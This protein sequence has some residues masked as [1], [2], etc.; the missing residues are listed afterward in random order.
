MKAL[1]M[2]NGEGLHMWSHQDGTKVDDLTAMIL[3][4]VLGI[5]YML[6]K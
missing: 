2:C 1:Y 6:V 3:E 4:Y 5:G